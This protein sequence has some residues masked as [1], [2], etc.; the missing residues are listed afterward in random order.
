MVFPGALDNASGCADLL[1]AA[2]ALAMSEI[3]PARTVVFIFFGGEECGLTGSR[4][5]VANPLWSPEKV[6]YM[7]NLDMVGNGTGFHLSGG[8]SHPGIYKH[9]NNSNEKY[10]HRVLSSSETRISYGRPRTDG[11]I[12]EKAGYKTLGLWTTGT[13]KKVYYHQP[14]D[15]PDGLTPEIME[16]AALLLYLGILSSANATDL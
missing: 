14:L 8:L 6:Q 7:I 10:I 9:F 1:G 11:A 13:V 16:D 2:Q 15:N 5:Y 12:L 4:H 3:K